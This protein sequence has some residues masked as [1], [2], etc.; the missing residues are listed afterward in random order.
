M[1]LPLSLEGVGTVLGLDKQKLTEG[2]ALIR[3]FC[4]PCS[5]MKSNSGRTRNLSHHDNHKWQQFKEYNK[6]DVETEQEIQA[7]LKNFPVPEFVWDE[8][9][10]DQRI[11]NRGVLVDRDFV[12]QAIQ[13]AC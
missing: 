11:N 13:T 5:A 12:K 1:G 9:V 8:Y 3:Y 6:R 2:K 7:K 4:V 10:L